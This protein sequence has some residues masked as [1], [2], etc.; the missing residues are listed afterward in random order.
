MG[1]PESAG[2]E[3]GARHDHKDGVCNATGAE[4]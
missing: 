1:V 2:T 4:P 3:Q